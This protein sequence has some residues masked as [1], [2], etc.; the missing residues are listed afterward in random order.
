MSRAIGRLCCYE[1]GASPSLFTWMEPSELVLHT[2]TCSLSTHYLR[3]HHRDIPSISLSFSSRNSGATQRTSGPNGSAI[4]F[5]AGHVA[6]VEAIRA[7][8]RARSR[9]NSAIW[10]ASPTIAFCT[11]LI[12]DTPA[13]TYTIAQPFAQPFAY[14][15]TCSRAN[16]PTHRLRRVRPRTR[17]HVRGPRG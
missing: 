14:T 17:G 5:Q 7:Q 10:R 2:R 15:I 8:P 1:E 4:A 13:I 11:T 6:A 12:I 3:L 9:H 16:A